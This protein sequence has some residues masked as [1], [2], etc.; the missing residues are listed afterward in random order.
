M[1]THTQ[2]HINHFAHY[3]VFVNDLL[4]S[5]RTRL[6]EYIKT[7][8]HI[9]IKIYSLYFKIFSFSTVHQAVKL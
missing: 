4:V 2:M 3:S 6:E 8:S 1:H 9:I 5:L 7:P